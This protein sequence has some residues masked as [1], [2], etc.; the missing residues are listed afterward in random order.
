MTLPFSQDERDSL[1]DRFA[2]LAELEARLFALLIAAQQTEHEMFTLASALARRALSDGEC[3]AARAFPVMCNR[4]AEA[5]QRVI[6]LRDQWLAAHTDAQSAWQAVLAK[7]AQAKHP[8]A[9]A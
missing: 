9:A 5:Q 3:E 7:M 4:L 6:S 2:K 8:E 1:E